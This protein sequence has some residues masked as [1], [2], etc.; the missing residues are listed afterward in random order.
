MHEELLT[1]LRWLYNKLYHPTAFGKRVLR[2]VEHL[3]EP[4]GQQNLVTQFAAKPTNRKIDLEITEVIGKISSL[5]T[6]ERTMLLQIGEA[7][8]KKPVARTHVM[9][10]LHY[11]MQIRYLFQYG[12]VWE[13]SLAS[14][15]SPFSSTQDLT[16]SQNK[17]MVPRNW[18]EL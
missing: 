14:F 9:R 7:T 1:G 12:G 3:K 2:F 6:D 10:M 8:A 15:L 13:P 17:C 16:L 11:Y 4:P 18:T 5:G